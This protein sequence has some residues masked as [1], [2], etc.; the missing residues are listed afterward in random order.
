MILGATNRAPIL[1]NRVGVSSTWQHLAI[2]ANDPRFCGLM[3]NRMHSGLANLGSSRI[4]VALP[5]RD[6]VQAAAEEQDSR[7]IVG[8]VSKATS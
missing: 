4:L 2:T 7:P 5:F 3:K 1:A 6:Q 8:K